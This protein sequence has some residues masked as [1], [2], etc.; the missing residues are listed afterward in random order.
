MREGGRGKEGGVREGGREGE[1]GRR[2]G[3]VWCDR[4]GGDSG[5][6]EGGKGEGGR[7]KG[8]RGRK[9]FSYLGSRFRTWA[10]CFRTRAVVFVRGRVVSV[11]G[12]SFLNVGGRPY[13]G[14]R[15]RWVPCRRRVMVVVVGVVVWCGRGA[16]VRRWWY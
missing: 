7:G 2:E 1:A 15:G 5:E 3:V 11:R 6:G 12:R 9:S 10:R 16:A 8:G 14:G 13:M 4:E